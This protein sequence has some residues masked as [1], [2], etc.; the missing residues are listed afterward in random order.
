MNFEEQLAADVREI[1][2]I[3]KRYL[4]KEEGYAK[5]VAEAVNYSVLAGGK[6][7]RP[8]LLLECCRLF[9]GREE[10]AAPFMAAIE[11]IHTYSLVHDDLPCM[12]NDEYRRGRKTTHAVYGEGM[13]VLAGDALL[14]LAFET[15][16]SAFSLTENEEELRRAAR[17]MQILSAKSGIGGMIGG[18]C[19]DTQAEEFPPE[20]V[21][22]ELLLYIHE[23]KTAAMIES[24]MMI[25]ALLAGAE[26]E[27]L[28]ALE[29]IGSKIG[30]AFQIRDDILDLT[31]S[32]QELGKQTG[33]DLKNNK[34]TYVS[35]NGMEAS[36]KE[37]RRL[38]EEA[39]QELQGLAE[40]RNEFLECLVEDLITRK[41]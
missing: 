26:K 20:K 1:E 14:N 31:S 12:D 19:A 41:K 13:A 15:A 30:L 35:L 17:A 2:E 9:G 16:S 11:F 22:Q 6:R 27:K 40:N 28:E 38:S 18:Q 25:G 24:P 23:N 3:L 39:L 7:L 32:L 36:E 21:T 4:P 29:R 8:M 10:L 34:V 5:T 37:V 33:S